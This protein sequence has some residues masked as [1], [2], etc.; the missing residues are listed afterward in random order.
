M[1]LAVPLPAAAPAV[2]LLPQPLLLGLL[3]LRLAVKDLPAVVPSE[4]PVSSKAA[5]KRKARE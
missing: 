2:G 5:G 1:P 3:A 4:P